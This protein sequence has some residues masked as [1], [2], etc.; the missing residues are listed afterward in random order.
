MAP[1]ASTLRRGVLL[2]L[3]MLALGASPVH[4]ATDCSKFA[5][6]SGSDSA[7]GTEAAP[8]RT[9]QRLADSLSAG[10]TGCLRGGSYTSSGSY[11]LSPAHGGKPGEPIVIRSYP[12]ERARLVGITNLHDGVDNVALADLTFEGTGS[13]NTIKIYAADTTIEGSEITNAWRGLSC[14]MLGSNSGAGQALRTTVRGNVFHACGA[15]ANG[16]KDHGIYAANAL[17][18]E[19]V[20]NVFYDSAAYAIQLYPNARRTRFAHNVVD[21]GSPSVR[22]GV[23]VSGDGSYAS[24]E[25]VIEHNVI[26]YAATYNVLSS[27]GGAIGGG[28]VAR[29]NCLWDG[30]LG[31]LLN[32]AGLT[33]TGNLTADPGFLD[34]SGRNYR[35]G[36]AS[37]CLAKVGYDTAAKVAAWN[38]PRA[39]PVPEPEPE[40]TPEPE[41]EVEPTPE[42]EVEPRSEPEPESEPGPTPKPDKEGERARG[43][44]A[45]SGRLLLHARALGRESRPLRQRTLGLRGVARG[46]VPRRRVVIQVAPAR[47]SWRTVAVTQMRPD[48]R[49]RL[50]LRVT[51]QGSLRVRAVIPGVARSPVARV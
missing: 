30:K 18:G 29:E 8:Y 5:A 32:G 46:T 10:Q 14:M 12:G 42:P 39:E 7:A 28:N 49:F 43:D 21:G 41:A 3:A 36:S 38:E 26:A 48:G 4:G 27:W 25:N 9:A 6:P 33:A 47:S 40:P 31:N 51:G 17:E 15:P 20:D 1:V 50:W 35:L 13:S 44:K 45:K 37:P 34:R 23:I 11:V 22:G 2:A 24:S 19:I 16:N